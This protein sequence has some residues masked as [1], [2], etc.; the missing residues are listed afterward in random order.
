MNIFHQVLQCLQYLHLEDIE[1]KHDVYGGK[2]SMIKF[3]EFLGK[4]AVKII[5]FKK[6]NNEVINKRAAE[7]I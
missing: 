5:N 7:I 4:H 1:N 2:D 6:K 3:F